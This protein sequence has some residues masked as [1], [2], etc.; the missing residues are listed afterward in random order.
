MEIVSQTE[1]KSTT[2]SVSIFVI[3]PDRNKQTIKCNCSATV[4]L[5]V[6]NYMQTAAFK[7][8]DNKPSPL[9]LLNFIYVMVWFDFFFVSKRDGFIS[10]F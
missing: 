4:R 6:I 7:F 2:A 10:A 8:Q 9:A 1:L 3:C 5:V